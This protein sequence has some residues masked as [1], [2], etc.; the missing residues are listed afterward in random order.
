[1]KEL[2][3]K[4]VILWDFDGVILDSMDIREYGFRKVLSDFP[5]DEVD[6]LIK[7]HR[8]NGGLSRYV[9]FGYF[10]EKIRNEEKEK[11]IKKW[12]EAYSVIM[13][14][15]LISEERLIKEVISFIHR[16]YQNYKMHIVSGSDGAELRYI[17]NELRIAHYFR[18]IAG[19]PT[20]KSELIREIIE[21][22]SYAK[23]KTCLIGDSIN[24]FEAAR[25]NNIDFFG[26]NNEKLKEKGTSYITSFQK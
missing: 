23:E 18:S 26:Y 19:S 17:A 14:R 5:K 8:E 3:N 24:D 12:A 7:F 13:K 4:G 11:K 22:H 1:M 16:H 9:K 20:P 6:K 2:L 21:S 25:E 10:L 15:N